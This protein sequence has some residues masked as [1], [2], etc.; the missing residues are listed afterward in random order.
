MKK[1][2]VSQRVEE[3]SDINEF[4]DCLDQRWYPLLSKYGLMGVPI[5]TFS[6]T[7]LQYLDCMNFDGFL[8]T[9]GND[10]SKL[11]DGTNSSLDRDKLESQLL[12]YATKSKLPVM[13]VCRGFQF[14]NMHLG[15]GLTRADGHVGARHHLSILKNP[16]N[17]QESKLEVNSF[18]GWVINQSDLADDLI[19]IAIAQDGTVEAAYHPSLNWLGIMWHPERSTCEIDNL[20]FDFLFK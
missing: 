20:I 2:G 10:L 19:P 1:I 3:Y 9:G 4:R 8:L 12:E 13:G 17:F 11:T 15:G 16:M 7:S 18:H 5:P 14:L 6:N